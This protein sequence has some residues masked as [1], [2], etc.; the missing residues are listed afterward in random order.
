MSS[1]PFP[2][3]GDDS[4]LEL[5]PSMSV[6]NSATP[7]SLLTNELRRL[8]SRKWLRSG[9]RSTLFLVTLAGVVGLLLFAVDYSFRLSLVARLASGLAAATLLLALL[10]RYVIPAWKNWEDLESLALQVEKQHE[11]ESD[12]VAALQFANPTQRRYGSRELARAVV[13]YVDE[14]TPSLNVFDG[15]SW[16]PL[17]NSL[18][19][20]LCGFLIWSGLAVFAPQA[21][22]VFFSRLLLS[23][24]SYPTRT[25]IEWIRVN[26]KT[27]DQQGLFRIVEGEPLAIEVQT[28]GEDPHI[29]TWEM[30]AA[31]GES[32]IVELKAD[33]L[34]NQKPADAEAPL[35]QNADHQL[36]NFGAV[37]PELRQS[38][39]GIVRAGDTQ[40][41]PLMID[42]IMRPVV[43]V[44]VLVEQPEYTRLKEGNRPP[45]R[46]QLQVSVLEGSKVALDI[47]SVKPLR[48]VTMTINGQ[49][50]ELSPVDKSSTKITSQSQVSSSSSLQS[51]GFTHWMTEPGSPLDTLKENL[52]F[53]LDVEDLD[54]LKLAEPVTGM[55][56]I[57][58]DKPP[59][60]AAVAISKLILP[61]ASPVITWGATDDYALKTVSLNVTATTESGQQRSIKQPVPLKDQSS[62]QRGQ[63]ALDL[64]SLGLTKGDEVR[65]IVEAVDERGHLPSQVGR[66][67]SLT[68]QVTDQSGILAGL[69]ETDQ[70]SA[71]QLDAIIQRELGIG[72][73]K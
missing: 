37:I 66:S 40:S 21:T 20:A 47:T 35:S 50:F 51:T 55:L 23:H 63:T 62:L 44:S 38:V 54:G 3:P 41:Q 29:A 52:T 70:Q 58:L 18:L 33:G 14:F 36:K 57:K 30:Q 25:Q 43:E 42:L 11:I 64:T 16:Q 6:R 7:L 45:A 28:S 31:P 46:G 10:I 15:F 32:L 26:G 67:E 39:R 71:R 68:F 24:E 60:V 5:N 4:I 22:R 49:L 34:K 59:R 12:L 53:Q 9:L 27:A 72:G 65:V 69:L 48:K 61:Q 2:H 8:Q 17:R 56:R 73:T 1:T 13:E 19:A